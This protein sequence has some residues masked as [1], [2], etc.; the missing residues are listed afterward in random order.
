MP[1]KPELTSEEL[2]L[3]K[4][5]K[6]KK[7]KKPDF[8]RQ[9]SWRYIRIKK[10]WRRPRGIDSKMRLKKKGWPKSPNS[11]Y[12]SPR[13]VRGIHP[14][15]FRD[16]L[17]NNLLDL[18]KINSKREAARISRVVGKRK[19]QKIIERADA[20]GIKILNRGFK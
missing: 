8:I 2:R 5:R 4:V 11:G 20:L 19:R 17:I 7:N 10:N 15:G 6:E 12:G 3:L 16:I 1:K 18:E 13:N 9:E 14:S